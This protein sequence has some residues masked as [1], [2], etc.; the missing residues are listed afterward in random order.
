MYKYIVQLIV[1]SI[2]FVFSML[3]AWYEGSAIIEHSYEWKYSTPFSSFFEI[4]V[5]TGKEIFA[6]DYFVYAA[7]FQPL[8][9]MIMLI[10]LLYIM[11]LL[12]VMLKKFNHSVATIVTFL[13]CMMLICLALVVAN[14]ST[15]GGRLLLLATLLGIIFFCSVYVILKKR[16]SRHINE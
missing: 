12:I 15:N 3:V 7:K 6:L 11:F 16:K 14:T 5:V 13:C 10:T 2:L 9:P 1:A 8:F 4:E